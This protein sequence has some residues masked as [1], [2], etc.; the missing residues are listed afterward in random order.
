M[1]IFDY[2]RFAGPFRNH[3]QENA[4]RLAANN[5][6]EIKFI[7]KRNFRKEDRLKAR[8]ADRQNPS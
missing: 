8:Q 4:E 3:L 5:G 1:G 2:P 6:M 7:R